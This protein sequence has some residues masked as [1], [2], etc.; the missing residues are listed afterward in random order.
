MVM[1]QVLGIQ[2]P[3]TG[4]KRSGV[5]GTNLAAGNMDRVATRFSFAHM[6][7]VQEKNY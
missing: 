7:T 1:F 4:L 3:I 6:N 2:I 5:R